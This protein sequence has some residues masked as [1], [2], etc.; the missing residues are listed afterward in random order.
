MYGSSFKVKI[1]TP[2]LLL[3]FIT[4]CARQAVF[5]SEPSGA[6]VHIDGKPIGIT[7]CGFEYKNSSGKDYDVTVE[8]EGYEPVTRT[9]KADE[10]DK[11]TRNKWL[12]AGLVWSP[13]W[14]GTLFT[15]KLHDTYE[16]VLK[17]KPFLYAERTQSPIERRF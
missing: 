13:L 5:I 12:A 9:V 2:L 16:F 3:F 1:F 17:K 11:K 10:I 8:M 7:P 15:K 4:G 14:L 6:I